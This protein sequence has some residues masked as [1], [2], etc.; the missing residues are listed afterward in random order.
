MGVWGQGTWQ[1]VEARGVGMG[2]ASSE[3]SWGPVP[4]SVRPWAASA[5]PY[6]KEEG[7]GQAVYPVGFLLLK[8]QLH[9]KQVECDSKAVSLLALPSGILCAHSRDEGT[10]GIRKLM[11]G[12]APSH[13]WALHFL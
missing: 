8:R 12:S 6:Q 13:W 5:F 2:P 9:L 4:L 7:Q 11:V 3:D 10:P 1:G